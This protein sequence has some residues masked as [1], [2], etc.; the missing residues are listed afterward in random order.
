MSVA[1]PTRMTKMSV[2]AHTRITK[3]RVAAPS[4]ITKNTDASQG[5]FDVVGLHKKKVPRPSA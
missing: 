4:R 5:D 2:A 1:A 3:M